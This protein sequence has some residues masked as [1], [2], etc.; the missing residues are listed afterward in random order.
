MPGP[1][2]RATQPSPINVRRVARAGLQHVRFSRGNCVP[3]TRCC[4]YLLPRNP[5][6]QRI[7]D[8]GTE[9]QSGD[10]IALLASNSDASVPSCAV[11]CWISAPAMGSRSIWVAL[12]PSRMSI[13]ASGL[14]NPSSSG[15]AHAIFASSNRESEL[16]LLV[17]LRRAFRRSDPRF[18][19][20]C[21]RRCRALGST[22]W[23]G[24]LHLP[25]ASLQLARASP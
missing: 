16:D 23:Q 14:S 21:Y 20:D 6:R 15:D 8:E 3:P 18:R 17:I 9:N 4:A 10:G 7:A 22:Q 5:V 24:S 25:V 11:L 1:R 13:I 2:R 12:E 19:P